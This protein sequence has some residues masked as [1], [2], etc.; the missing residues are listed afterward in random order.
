MVIFDNPNFKI[1]N[2]FF[3]GFRIFDKRTGR[4]II[5]DRNLRDTCVK[6]W[7]LLKSMR[8]EDPLAKRYSEAFLFDMLG[9]VSIDPNSEHA[10][11]M[12][13]SPEFV[14]AEC[15]RRGNM[16]FLSQQS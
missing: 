5:P 1:T 2:G 12:M 13:L 6:A 4:K 11:T 15:A 16:L 8:Y 9:D 3:S 10:M 14:A 7:M